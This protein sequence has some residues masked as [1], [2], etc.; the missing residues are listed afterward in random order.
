MN[1]PVPSFR[2]AKQA[3]VLKLFVYDV[4]G[5]DFFGEGVT[6]ANVQQSIKTAGAIDEIVVHLNSPGGDAFEGIAIHNIVRQAGV[7]VTSIVEGLAASAA[8]VIAMAGDT[9]KICDGA[10]LMIH[11]AWCHASGYADDL[12]KT[13]DLCEKNSAEI[14]GIYAKRSGRAQSD[15]QALMDAET[16]MTAAEAIAQGF[17]D[18]PL[19]TTAEQSSQARA[20]A[21]QFNLASVG[22]KPPA[23]ALVAARLSD[24]EQERFF[25]AWRSAAK[26]AHGVAVLSPAVASKPKAGDD[27]TCECEPCLAGD[28]DNC[29]HEDCDCE[30]CTCPDHIDDQ[31]QIDLFDLLHRRAQLA[32]Y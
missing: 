26:S 22:I 8:S 11:N 19:A 32:R 29:S 13:A 28:C 2:A 10:M 27:C 1:F 24:K 5:S 6:A 25:E 30:G 12:R 16:W 21:A 7:P 4:I 14:A 20:L 23:S 31:A 18:E 15:V 9:I 3:N 17:A